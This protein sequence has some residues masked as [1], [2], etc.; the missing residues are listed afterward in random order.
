MAYEYTCGAENQTAPGY[1][2]RGVSGPRVRCCCHGPGSCGHRGAASGGKGEPPPPEPPPPVAPKT[3]RRRGATAYHPTDQ[4]LRI[5]VD[6]AQKILTDGWRDAVGEQ[7]ATV[8]NDEFWNSGP[9]WSR[10]KHPDCQL[11]AD[12]ANVMERAKKRVHNAISAMADEGLGWLG[13][14]TLERRIGAEFARRIPIPGDEQ[15]AAVIHGLRIYGIW[16]CLPN[17]ISYVTARCPCFTPL[18]KDKTEEELERVLNEKL[19]VLVAE[20][21]PTWLPT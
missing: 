12:L 4:Q 1:C 15:I 8:L 19:N 11:L 14:P 20:Y 10:R 16:V 6:L 21:G 18:A 9:R 3:P 7:L 5:S 17:G 2:G 13:R